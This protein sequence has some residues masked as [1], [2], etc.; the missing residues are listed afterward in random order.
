MK[1][2]I[3]RPRAHGAPDVSE[4]I[5]AIWEN[6]IDPNKSRQSF[7]HDGG[8]LNTSLKRNEYFDSSKGLFQHQ[9]GT[10]LFKQSKRSN[11]IAQDN[12]MK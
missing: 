9:D 12:S 2:P 7:F 10:S 8:S 6:T 1:F 3:Y 11:S 5:Q 4:D